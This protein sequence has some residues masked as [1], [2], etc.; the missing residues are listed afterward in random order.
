MPLTIRITLLFAP[1]IISSAARNSHIQ[2]LMNNV[3]MELLV[4]EKVY[5]Q[6][7]GTIE[8][9]QNSCPNMHFH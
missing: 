7:V 3:H 1:G 9:F 5:V 6:F 4:I 8:V 2:Y